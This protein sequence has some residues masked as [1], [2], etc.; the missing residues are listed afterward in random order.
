MSEGLPRLTLSWEVGSTNNYSMIHLFNIPNEVPYELLCNIHIPRRNGRQSERR[1]RRVT[2]NSLVLRASAIS[3]RL[4]LPVTPRP[5]LTSL[6]ASNTI[7][8]TGRNTIAGKAKK[9]G[10]KGV[11]A[12]NISELKHQIADYF[13]AQL[14]LL[15]DLC[16]DRNYVSMNFIELKFSYDMLL[17]LL[18]L[19]SSPR[20]FRA[21]V[22]RLLRC[23]YVDRDPQVEIKYPRL[24]R[25]SLSL[26][27]GNEI[28]QTQRDEG[29]KYLFCLLQENISDFLHNELET[30][31]CDELSSEMLA[32]LLSLMKFGFYHR[33]PQL[34]DVISP[35]TRALDDHRC[36]SGQQMVKTN[37]LLSNSIQTS[38]SSTSRSPSGS[39]EQGFSIWNIF[40]SRK[41]EDAENEE[42][43]DDDVV[44]EISF[45]SFLW[46][47]WRWQSGVAPD[48]A[49]ERTISFSF[50]P[51]RDA[52][53]DI[54]KSPK[55]PRRSIPKTQSIS[56][57]LN[58]RASSSR[59]LAHTVGE[60]DESTWE[61]DFLDLV[62]TPIF[63]TFIVFLVLATTVI[64][65]LSIVQF[66]HE[67][68]MGNLD[69][70]ISVI[71]IAEITL[72]IYCTYV[73]YNDVLTF[74]I[75]PYKLLDVS[76]V[77]SSYRPTSR[78]ILFL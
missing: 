1:T 40:R 49:L 18:K 31:N 45:L 46:K 27:G 47:P 10:A 6:R 53:P 60:D 74:I 26:G 75:N 57:P 19:P 59:S 43:D 78:L 38:A 58:G 2:E 70:T 37:S 15:A 71:F 52:S 14:Y 16:L 73:V 69:L 23:L 20:R 24:I 33:I 22:C 61:E 55:K 68:T 39:E 76:V 65:V 35:L 72:R 62:E 67:Q 4:T 32:L 36:H 56:G 7:R 28:N 30:R 66:P 48:D 5:L 51:V 12:P 42:D 8:R 29:S 21:P 41:I 54:P 77:I 13:C 3:R 44:E 64:A 11:Q 9:G 17:T 34:K 50:S 25:T 63:I